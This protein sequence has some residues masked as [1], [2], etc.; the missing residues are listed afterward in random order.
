MHTVDFLD[1]R[2][3]VVWLSQNRIPG[4]LYHLILIKQTPEK[5]AYKPGLDYLLECFLPSAFAQIISVLSEKFQN[6]LK[7]GGCNPPPP[8]PY[9]CDF[10]KYLESGATI[11][12]TY[13]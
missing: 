11:K 12:V 9:A 10:K 1:T 8:G 5:V 3:N 6:F 2:L 4:S 7:V 13:I